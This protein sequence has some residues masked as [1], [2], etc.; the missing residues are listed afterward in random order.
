MARDD[1]ALGLKFEA[2][3]AAARADRMRRRVDELFR[4]GVIATPAPMPPGKAAKRAQELEDVVE[5]LKKVVEKQQSE[6]A[7]TRGRAA[8]AARGAEHAR[9]AKEARLKMREMQEA[10]V[11]LRRVKEAHR[12]VLQ[13]SQ[14]LER[15]NAE[16]RRGGGGEGGG[17]SGSLPGGSSGRATSD[18]DALLAA[19]QAEAADTALALAETRDALIA[20]RKELDAAREDAARAIAAAAGGGGAEAATEAELRRLAAENA[21]LRAELDALDPAFFDEVMDMK[22]AY[23]EQAGVLEKYEELLRRY[24]AQLGVPFTPISPGSASPE[25]A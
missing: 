24:A 6:L 25:E 15:E 22:R 7:A 10:M 3:Q 18:A 1:A 23:H 9:A 14:K 19:A 16:L 4:G 5:A 20:Q 12:D 2:E 13:R 11:S 8:A 17:G 21:D